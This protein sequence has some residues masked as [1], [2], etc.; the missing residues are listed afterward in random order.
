M[1]ELTAGD[2]LD[3]GAVIAEVWPHI[4]Q[5][6]LQAASEEASADKDSGKAAAAGQHIIGVLLKHGREGL[7]EVAA[8]LHDET[9]ADFRRRPPGEILDTIE[10][11]KNSE[12]GRDFFRRLPTLLSGGAPSST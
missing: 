2:M 5:Q 8:N 12:A 6:L 3:L 4:D 7:V 11:I 10:A 1:R 9:V